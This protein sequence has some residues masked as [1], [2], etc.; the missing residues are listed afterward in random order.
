MP[1]SR[2]AIVTRNS[3]S[4]ASNSRASVVWALSTPTTAS[5]QI[6]GT[7]SIAWRSSMS[8]PRTQEK[9]GSVVTSAD[10]TGAALRGRPAR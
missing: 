2:A 9:R 1:A 5:F 7:E 4:S 10:M 3:T 8:K 6:S